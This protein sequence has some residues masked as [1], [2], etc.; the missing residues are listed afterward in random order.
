MVKRQTIRPTTVIRA[1]HRIAV[2][3]LAGREPTAPEGV[4][5]KAVQYWYG[6][7][8]EES[9]AAVAAFYCAGQRDSKREPLAPEDVSGW[10]SSRAPQFSVHAQAAADYL[11][12]GPALSTTPAGENEVLRAKLIVKYAATAAEQGWN[13]F[14]IGAAFEAH[15]VGAAS[16]YDGVTQFGA[17]VENPNDPNTHPPLDYAG[18]NVSLALLVSDTA[19]APHFVRNF[20]AQGQP[21][22]WAG[23]PKSWKSTAAFDL[24]ISV[25]TGK[26]FLDFF[27]VERQADVLILTG[28][29]GKSA[30]AD[31]MRRV[32]KRK[33]LDPGDILGV[34][35]TTFV[36]QFANPDDLQSL[37]KRITRSGA[38]LVII[39]PLAPCLSA[40]A[41]STLAI[42]YA[43]LMAATNAVA[44]EGATL[45]VA[46]HVT[47]GAR[48]KSLGLRASSGAGVSE[49][50]RAW[51][52]F[53]RVGAFDASKGTGTLSLT[54]GSSTG[55]GGAW[56]VDI[57]EGL[58]SDPGGR[59]W[60]PT[61]RSTSGRSARRTTSAGTDADKVLTAVRE[62]GKPSTVS[63]IRAGARLNADRAKVAIGQL[64]A[65]GSLLATTGKVNGRESALYQVVD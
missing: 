43:E 4:S 14:D 59:V 17:C 35:Y 27:P 23:E 44:A 42:A 52:M 34:E 36:P 11:R 31:T 64:E 63:A 38:E 30:A 5:V 51:T 61:V 2:E 50:A 33:G 1:L 62:L 19:D 32:C 12:A 18:G 54:S 60:E 6:E 56:R 28:E 26:P 55:F 49:W 65:A 29:N 39:D 20:V 46:H 10:I 58:H 47:K 37:R 41:A 3:M 15:S 57:R 13:V 45:L 53:S 7:A 8:G 24:A 22:V 40:G 25:A 9:S 48:V 16:R 21:T